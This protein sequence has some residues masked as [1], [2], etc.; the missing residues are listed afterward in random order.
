MRQPD[1]Q[2]D[3]WGRVGSHLVFSACLSVIGE[4]LFGRCRRRFGYSNLGGQDANSGLRMDLHA[5]LGAIPSVTAGSDAELLN[6]SD[7]VKRVLAMALGAR[8]T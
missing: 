8:R 5:A 2:K 3:H 1:P 7:G 4:F 6:P